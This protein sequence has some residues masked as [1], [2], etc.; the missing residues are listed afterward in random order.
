MKTHAYFRA[1]ASLSLLFLFDNCGNHPAPLTAPT[2]EPGTS[3]SADEH[4]S[5]DT[6]TKIAENLSPKNEEIHTKKVKYI[7]KRVFE[8]HFESELEKKEKHRCVAVGQFC[9]K[10]KTDEELRETFCHDNLN[11]ICD[12]QVI[13]SDGASH[14]VLN[15]EEHIISTAVRSQPI[16]ILYP[17]IR[18]DIGS[19]KS[20]AWLTL[21]DFQ[22]EGFCEFE[23]ITK[24]N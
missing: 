15:E 3:K 16:M 4:Q 20:K 8:C 5:S 1:L 10:S 11:V 6:P 9:V 7:T 24:T 18:Q 14:I 13:Y 23:T 22:A 2:V 21:N 19:F 12:G 17:A